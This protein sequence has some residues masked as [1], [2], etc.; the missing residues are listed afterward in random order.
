MKVS[1]DV[2]SETTV[3]VLITV[4]PETVDCQSHFKMVA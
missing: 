3:V 4:E 2:V 1:V